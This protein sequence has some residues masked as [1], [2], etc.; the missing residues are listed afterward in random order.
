MI[1]LS[2][3]GKLRTYMTTGLI[4]CSFAALIIY[5]VIV[6]GNKEALPFMTF[7][8]T[9][10]NFHVYCPVDT[11][12][13]AGYYKNVFGGNY[14]NFNS[15]NSSSLYVVYVQS[16]NVTTSVFIAN[17]N[18][19]QDNKDLGLYYCG[20][21][22]AWNDTCSNSQLVCSAPGPMFYLPVDE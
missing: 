18:T 22:R 3:S 8:N 21:A 11:P 5:L 7:T 12:T 15:L 20:L 13:A 14:I 4:G 2:T 16:A 17:T 9:N 10:F 1:P 6:G 19:Y